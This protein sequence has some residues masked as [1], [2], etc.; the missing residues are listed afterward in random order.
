MTDGLEK[1]MPWI[2]GAGVACCA[3]VLASIVTLIDQNGYEAG[4][5][6]RGIK[7]AQECAQ[8]PGFEQG[9]DERRPNG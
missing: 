9:W 8:M 4:W 6:D 3:L 1:L 5:R 2:V 7:A